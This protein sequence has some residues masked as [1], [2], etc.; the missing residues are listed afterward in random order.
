MNIVKIIKSCTL[1]T[2]AAVM[3]ASCSDYLDVDTNPNNPGISTPGLTLPVAQRDLASLNATQMTYLGQYIAYNWATPSNWSSNQEFSRYTVNSG[4]YAGIF[5][6]SY[7][8]IFRDLTYV[9]NYTDPAGST[10]YSAYKSIATILKG[11]QY[12]YLVDLYG[13]VPYTE[14]NLRAGNITP[15]YDDAQ[16]V[17]KAVIA[18]LTTAATTA[19]SVPANAENPHEK[20]IINGGDMTKWAQFANTVKLR[21]L[22]R[23][24][25]TNQDAYIRAQIALID[26]NGAGYITSDIAANPGYVDDTNKQSPFFGYFR[27]PST[28]LE[29]D[30]GDFT[31]ASDYTVGYLTTT[32]D[33]RLSRLYAGATTGGAFKGAP[34]TTTLP[35]TGFTSRDLAKVGPGLLVSATQN[36]TIMSLPESL[37]LQAEAISRGYIAGGDAA[38]KAKYEQAV[39]ASFTRLA[40]PNAATAATTYLAQDIPNVSWDSSPNKVQAIITQKWVALNGTSSIELWIEK[41]RTGFPAN[42]PQPAEGGGKRPVRLLYPS[43]EISRNSQNVPAQT[44]AS[45]F[46]DNPFWK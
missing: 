43:S 3:T 37:L 25:N 44:A 38:A 12:Q 9:Q 45:A 41:T 36:Q 10:D 21:M 19:L 15:K 7:G 20:D 42:L 35:G 14:A 8:T 32:N 16:T 40:V 28:G 46:N 33:P 27:R 26:A 4:F 18:E 1:L 17:Y 5:E 11:F 29:T 23:L 39:R 30:R 2:L 13:N 34:Q 24:S 22:V 31:V 6:T